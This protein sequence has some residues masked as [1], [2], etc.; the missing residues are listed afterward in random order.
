MFVNISPTH[1]SSQET[2]CSLRFANQVLQQSMMLCTYIK[3]SLYNCIQMDIA[4]DFVLRI[5]VINKV[6]YSVF[7]IFISN[8]SLPHESFLRNRLINYTNLFSDL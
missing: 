7:L 1:A 4:I 6:N 3:N 8:I 5:R 2:L